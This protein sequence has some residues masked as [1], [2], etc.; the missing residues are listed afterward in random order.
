MNNQVHR[1]LFRKDG[2]GKERERKNDNLNG[3]EKYNSFST[4]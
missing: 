2:E 4:A 3:L 1:T